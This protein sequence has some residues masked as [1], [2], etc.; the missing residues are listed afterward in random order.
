MVT[1]IFLMQRFKFIFCAFFF[2][3]GQFISNAQLIDS[4]AKSFQSKPSLYGNYGSYYSFISSQFAGVMNIKLGADFN[5]TTKIGIGYNWIK[6][7][8]D[9]QDA[10]PG[11]YHSQLY[12]RYISVFFEYTY[13][14]TD[15]WEASIPAQIGFGNMDYK[16]ELPNGIT[17]N[18]TKKWF[19]LY[20][21]ITTIQYRFLR[22]FAA[23]AGIGYRIVL[24]NK[25]G[26]FDRFTSVIFVLKSRFYFGDVIKDLRKK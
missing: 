8:L 18:S 23:G 1:D 4:I 7:G 21:P 6:K 12:M 9:K 10:V 24:P 16:N 13:F 3:L 2:V 20:E 25:P 5:K 14:K 22:Y 17:E 15:H 19:V 11:Y 26:G